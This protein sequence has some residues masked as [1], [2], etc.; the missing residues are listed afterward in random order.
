MQNSP[1][2][3]HSASVARSAPDHISG[4]FFLNSSGVCRG[5]YC[6]QSTFVFYLIQCLEASERASDTPESKG[7]GVGRF[8]EWFV[9]PLPLLPGTGTG[10]RTR[11][12]GLDGAGVQPSTRG[13]ESSS[14]VTGIR[15]VWRPLWVPTGLIWHQRGNSLIR[16]TALG[17]TCRGSDQGLVG[18]VSCIPRPYRDIFGLEWTQEANDEGV[19]P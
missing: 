6:L 9:L 3:L 14:C 17:L 8:D 13:Q 2:I 19:I 1:G 18:R 10:V 4:L 7:P 15:R 11:P 5:L 16:A 12:Q